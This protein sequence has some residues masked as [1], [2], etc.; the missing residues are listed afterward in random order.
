MGV[1]PP[2][3]K[4]A[5]AGTAPVAL[6]FQQLLRPILLDGRQPQ[7]LCVHKELWVGGMKLETQLSDS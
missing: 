5:M 6:G 4:Q 7:V 2:K 1:D 3:G